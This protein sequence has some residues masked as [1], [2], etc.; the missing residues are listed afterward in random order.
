VNF[1][2]LVKYRRSIRAFQ[3]APLAEEKLHA[4]LDAANSAPSAGNYQSFEI[5]LVKG[6]EGSAALAAAT[7]HQDFV[8]QAP[9][10]LI[11]CANPSRC[12]EQ[13]GEAGSRLC[14]LQDATIACTFAMLAAT[15]MG[16]AT[17][18]I[19]AFDPEVVRQVI[20]APEGVTP[21]A[22]LPVGYAAEQ[23]ERTT[24]RPLA[25]LVHEVAG[26]G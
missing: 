13:Y 11:F 26:R 7:F 25:D 22:V 8:A 2:D 15:D 1:F 14:S 6:Q 24:R 18:W 9:V 21:V 20:E 4:I 17:V 5:Y 12:R 23:P 3:P 16:L 10:V 19:G